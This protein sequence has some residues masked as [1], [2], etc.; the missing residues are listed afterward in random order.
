[1]IEKK[2]IVIEEQKKR[3][4]ILEEYLRLGRARLY[5]RS[6]EKFS[7]QGEIFNEAELTECATDPA[8]ED[9]PDGEE[10]ETEESPKPRKQR[11]GRKPLSS[12]LPRVQERIELSEE[13]KQG[14]IETFF[15][16]VREELHPK[17]EP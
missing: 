7:G 2:S 6:S 16:K 13:E 17:R 10:P 12:A 14:A 11:K 4:A 15:T 9:S 8:E 3:I 1:M 5:G